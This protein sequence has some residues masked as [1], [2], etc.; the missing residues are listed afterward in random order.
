MTI[1]HRRTIPVA[2]LVAA[3]A[4]CAGAAEP[5]LPAPGEIPDA[6]GVPGFDTR[7][8]PG[9]EV[10]A[11]WRA[12]SPYRWVGYYLPAPCYTGTSWEG[13]RPAL[14]RMGWGTAVL[15]VGE[16]DW[17]EA[18]PAPAADPAPTPSPDAPRCTRTN[19]TP[20]RGSADAGWAAR[21]AAAEGF[22]EGTVVYLDVERVESVSPELSA[23]VRA[24]FDAMLEDARYI[25]G[26]YA[27]EENAE[28]L[29]ATAGAAFVAA[30]RADRPRLWVVST[31]GF[32]LRRGPTESGFPEA[33]IWQ[34]V[35]DTRETWGGHRLL[36]DANVAA[37]PNP[38]G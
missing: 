14:E 15:F 1:R 3:L 33:R 13:R 38:S 19:L 2:L 22:P 27:H 34:G 24:W 8:Y 7:E 6:R 21:G 32:N 4:A 17:P 16:Q 11:A 25:P 18:D 20:D 12:A 35:L 30:G 5:S 23:Y 9:D 10:M 26:L 29:M 36:I 37:D 28:D 31:R